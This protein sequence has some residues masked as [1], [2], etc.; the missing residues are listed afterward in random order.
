MFLGDGGPDGAAVAI[1]LSM[2]V[3]MEWKNERV[4][5][6]LNL[7]LGAFLFFSPWIF[8]FASGAPT[9]NAVVSGIVIAVLSIAALAAFTVWEEWL[10]LIL[11][12]WVLVSPWVL[13]FA[14]TTAAAVAVVVGILVAVIA[15][16]ELW[17]MYRAGG[18]TAI[19]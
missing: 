11:G 12:L 14:G 16:I 2:E 9:Q 18:L 15:A 6:V 17:M 19:R 1:G 3:A 7:V 10:N 8:G 5:D 13:A 4:C